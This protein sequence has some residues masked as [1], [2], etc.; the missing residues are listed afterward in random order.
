M[1]QYSMV[2]VPKSHKKA[3]QLVRT[4]LIEARIKGRLPQVVEEVLDPHVCPVCGSRK[5]TE[6][7]YEYICC[8]NCG[9]QKHKVEMQS[10]SLEGFLKAVGIGALF[11]LGLWTLLKALETGN[12]R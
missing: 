9:A 3:A 7:R 8:D 2:R 5:L 1:L 10:N 4:K 12:R 11:G 6:V